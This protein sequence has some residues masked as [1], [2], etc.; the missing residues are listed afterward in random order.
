MISVVL[1]VSLGSGDIKQRKEQEDG[2][3]DM[4]D[5]SVVEIERDWTDMP[6][7]CHVI[8]HVPCYGGKTASKTALGGI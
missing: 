7:C 4:W 6:T 2:R 3:Y 8:V 1:L 5:L